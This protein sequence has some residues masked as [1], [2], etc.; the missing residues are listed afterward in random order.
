MN[1]LAIKTVGLTL[2]ALIASFVQGQDRIGDFSLLDQS[3]YFHQMSWYDDNKAIAFLVQ[4][5][6]DESVEKALPEFF[7]LAKA[8]PAGEIQFF[9]INSMGLHNR[10]EVQ[11]EM[12]RLGIEIPVLMDD[13]QIIGEA[14]GIQRTAE[15]ILFDP[16]KFTVIYR[17]SVTTEIESILNSVV[18][19]QKFTARGNLEV[20][21]PIHYAA[22]NSHRQH[23]P[24]YEQDIAPIIEENCASCHR[25]S[26]IAPFDTGVVAHDQRSGNDEAYATGTN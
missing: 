5:N 11:A 9:M 4:A 7:R 12:A 20:G 24:S 14:L 17:G 13:A 26:G 2:S 18:A 19:G 8:F 1:S 3:G 10:E 22:A 25:E 15:F 21:Q 23:V 16:S 6:R